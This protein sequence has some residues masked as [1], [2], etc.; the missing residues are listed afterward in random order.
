M[1][2]T[3]KK[4][5]ELLAETNPNCQVDRVLE[6]FEDKRGTNYLCMKTKKIRVKAGKFKKTVEHFNYNA[7]EDD[8]DSKIESN[9][10]LEI[11]Q[12]FF[13]DKSEF[14]GLYKIEVRP[15]TKRY[16]K[17][18]R[19][20]FHLWAESFPHF[21]FEIDTLDIPGTKE[22]ISGR[23][24]PYS[25]YKMFKKTGPFIP[26]IRFGIYRPYLVSNTNQRID[27]GD[28]FEIIFYDYVVVLTD[29]ITN[30]HYLLL[31]R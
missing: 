24:N 7:L 6:T 20:V 27:E 31:S 4:L 8:D 29:D 17:G 2:L 26:S 30:S 1:P 9:I 15:K 16:K 28:E 18:T 23:N 22:I 12:D 11:P 3:K 25:Y 19:P 14:F 10:Y 13:D 21:S 5:N